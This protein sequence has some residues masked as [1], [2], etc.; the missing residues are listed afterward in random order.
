MWL[1]III[2]IGSDFHILCFYSTHIQSS[3]QNLGEGGKGPVNLL[4]GP[5]PI[6]VGQPGAAG[7]RGP[8]GPHG[9]YVRQ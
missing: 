2:F 9:I 4:P 7:P 3:S 1:I 8:E 5:L 6:P